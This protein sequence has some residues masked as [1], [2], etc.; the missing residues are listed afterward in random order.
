MV[1]ATP[2]DTWS[3]VAQALQAQGVAIPG[4]TSLQLMLGKRQ[5]CSSATLSSC[6]VKDDTEL[7]VLDPADPS[8]LQIF[9]TVICPLRSMAD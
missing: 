6:N 5:L 7:E 8:C 2:T 4:C 9:A 1:R 3:T